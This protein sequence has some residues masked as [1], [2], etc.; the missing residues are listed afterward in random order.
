MAGDTPNDNNSS[1][2]QQ[3]MGEICRLQSKVAEIQKEREEE[4]EA[5]ANQDSEEEEAEDSQP[6]V[7]TLWDA[8]VPTNF[9]LKSLS[10]HVSM[11]KPTRWNT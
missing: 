4:K 5:E 3:A 7:Q 1:T 8:Q 11:V 10:C 9:K 2:L 6:L